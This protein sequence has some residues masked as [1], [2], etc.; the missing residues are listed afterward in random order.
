MIKKLVSVWLTAALMFSLCAF[1]VFAQEPERF[2]TVSV[3][4]PEGEEYWTQ[5]YQTWNSMLLRY[6]DDKSPIPLSMYYDG[7]MF[8]KIPAENKDRGV[9]MFLSEPFSFSDRPADEEDERTYEF[10]V[11][12]KLSKTGVIK[13]DENGNANPAG[14][15]TRAEAT[16]MIMRL[17]GVDS[18]GAADSGFSDISSEEWYANV[19][20][21]AKEYGIAKGDTENTF[22][23]DRNITR[24]E[25]TAM[26]ARALWTVGFQVEDKN[27]TA[28]DIL[29]L[30][31]DGPYD[32]T[33]KISDWA[34]SAYKTIGA[35]NLIENNYSEMHLFPQKYATRYDTALLLDDIRERFQVYPR[36]I[37]VQYGFDKKMPVIDGSTSTY[38]FTDAIYSN[39]FSNGDFHAEKPAKHSKSHT[40]YER[41]IAGEIDAM[42]ASVYPAEDILQL[43][44]ENDVE[45]ELIPIAYDAM[46]FFT[47]ADNPA[48]EL[49]KEQISEIYVNNKYTNWNEIGGTDALLYPYARNYDSGSHAQMERHFLNGNDIHEKIR[50]ET[51]SVS[52]ANVL[53]DVMDAE[54]QEPKGYALGYSIYYY[55]HNMDLF[56]ETKTRLKL[57]AVDGVYPND[58]TIADGSYPLSNNTYVVIR[59]SE[60][61]NSPA[62]KFADFML[63]EIGQQ[64]VTQA[65]FGALN[66][67]GKKE[68]ASQNA[69]FADKMNAQMP[70]DKNYMFSP[71]SIKVALALAANGAEG[72]TKEE[73][74]SAIDVENLDEFNQFS[75]DLIARYSQTENLKLNIANSI[76]LNKDK[77]NQK[78]SNSFKKTAA[79]YLDADAKTVGEANAVKEI[80][81]WVS[82]KT[83][84]KITQIV[85]D[86]DFW[87]MLVNAIYFKAAWQNEFHEGATKTDVFHN[88]DGTVTKTDFMFRPSYFDYAELDGKK[89]IELPYQNSF[90]KYSEAGEYIGTE[91]YENAD[92]RMYAMLCEE[93]IS[94]EEILNS[95]LRE[96]KFSSEYIN[97]NLP[98]FKIEYEAK[99]NDMLINIGISKAFEE[100]AEFQKMFD[101]GNMWLWE[102]MH[103]TYINVDEKGTEAAAVTDFSGGGSALPP[104]PMEL[105]FDRPFT[106]IIRDDISGETLFMGRVA[107]F[108]DKK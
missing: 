89:I 73:I 101:S 78:F 71:F 39:L 70:A 28:Q 82:D 20:A 31:A 93:D 51:T 9:E 1:P 5:S 2:V 76:W 64:C 49:T 86:T 62:R 58:E 95:A 44:K 55:F 84:Q 47:N 91:W 108:S 35:F 69:T 3:P 12:E 75:K 7:Q 60:P 52:M 8:A 46:V 83:N 29:S 54:T 32:D 104:E 88:A 10:H 80:N 92:I 63:T 38:P 106:F 23:P 68:E 67:G 43:A 18:L 16:A 6:Q 14:N 40:S 36:Q 59:K 34:L 17:M 72:E 37:A 42:I 94:P 11:M 45:L 90:V 13:G 96:E 50:K 79:E 74:L 85:K 103:K 21:R 99:L 33:D 15:V 97:L 25:L 4:C 53:T 77:T 102:S 26:A 107:S 19:I 27:A 105:K 22:S 48:S 98:K 100:G 66:G 41:L 24:E 81:A 65:G 87:T 61:A 56:Y 57:L 30:M